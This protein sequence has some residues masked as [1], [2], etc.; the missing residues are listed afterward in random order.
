MF[1]YK[2]LLF[3]ENPIVLLAIGACIGFVPSWLLNQQNNKH[4]YRMFVQEKKHEA[5]LEFLLLNQK[6]A[7]LY[8]LKSSSQEKTADKLRDE[9]FHLNEIVKSKMMLYYNEKIS[10]MAYQILSTVDPSSQEEAEEFN[11]RRPILFE[12]VT[13]LMKKDLEIT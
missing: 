13:E 12:E 10:A 2:V 9:I 6:I 1:L 4:R 5:Y 7:T 8:L 3:L 11:S